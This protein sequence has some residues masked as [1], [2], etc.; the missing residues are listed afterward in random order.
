MLAQ[1]CVLLALFGK[2]VEL[3]PAPGREQL[4]NL[5][6]WGPRQAKPRDVAQL[7]SC[8]AAELRGGRCVVA[9]MCTMFEFV[10][11]LLRLRGCRTEDSAQVESGRAK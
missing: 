6:M 8:S 2:S 11:R 7:Y 10:N 3:E 9:C 4:P 5:G 1:P